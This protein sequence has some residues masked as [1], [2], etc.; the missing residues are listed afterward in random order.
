MALEY[1]LGDGA[2]AH[3]SCSLTLCC[4]LTEL[5]IGVW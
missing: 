1:S 4:G 5:V 3:V 2:D